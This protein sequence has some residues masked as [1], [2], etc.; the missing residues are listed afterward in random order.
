MSDTISQAKSFLV[1]MSSGDQIE[2]DELAPF[3]VNLMEN[4]T[5]MDDSRQLAY[6]KGV[7]GTN[8][9]EIW[10]NSLKVRH[11]FNSEMS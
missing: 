3:L 4:Q 5:K 11:D 8:Y 1:T 9:A 6:L 2:N 7:L 10:K